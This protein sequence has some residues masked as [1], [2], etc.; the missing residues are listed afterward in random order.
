ML[1][2]SFGV[3]STTIGPIFLDAIVFNFEIVK[4]VDFQQNNKVF[5][6]KLSFRV[7]KIYRLF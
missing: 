7:E 4:I 1:I 6:K 5:K 3:L 2:F